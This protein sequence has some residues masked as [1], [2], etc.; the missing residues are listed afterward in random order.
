MLR[1]LIRSAVTVL[2]ILVAVGCSLRKESDPYAWENPAPPAPDMSEWNTGDPDKRPVFRRLEISHFDF[3]NGWYIVPQINYKLVAE[4]EGADEVY[5]Q[6]F[7]PGETPNPDDDG[8]LHS[9]EYSPVVHSE[10]NPNVWALTGIS[11]GG[12]TAG[13][14]AVAVN[15]YGRAVS[16][17]LFIAWN[18]EN[19]GYTADDLKTPF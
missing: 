13:F 19:S 10:E 18:P 16:P 11:S 6:A 12:D 8:Y 4:V 1:R 15:E 7:D 14:Y 5:F 2:L 17:I 3:H 9:R